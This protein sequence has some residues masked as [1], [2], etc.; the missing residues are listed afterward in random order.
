MKI[1]KVTI[2]YDEATYIAEGQDAQ[3]WREWMLDAEQRAR[4]AHLPV[5]SNWTSIEDKTEQVTPGVPVG[6][7]PP[8]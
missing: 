3:T 1:Q 2:E 7:N 5:W 4:D 6:P 8:S